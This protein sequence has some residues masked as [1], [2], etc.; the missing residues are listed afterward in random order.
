[1]SVGWGPTAATAALAAQLP[2]Y[3]WI[4]LH[5]GAPG[6]DGTSNIAT[7]STRKQVTWGTPVSG[8]GA[9]ATD[10]TW[11]NVAGTET[12]LYWSAWTAASSGTFGFSGTLSALPKTAGQ[13]FLLPAGGLVVA[14]TLAT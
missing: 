5:T 14:V 13:T 4:Q 11:L 7:E 10:L 2:L 6:A 3:P 12:Y 9:S 1:M 8:S